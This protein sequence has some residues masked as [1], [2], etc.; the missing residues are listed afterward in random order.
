MRV[1]A[2]RHGFSRVLLSR[3]GPL[4]IHA[5]LLSLSF[6]NLSCH[7]LSVRVIGGRERRGFESELC[8]NSITHFPSQGVGKGRVLQRLWQYWDSLP[9]PHTSFTIHT[10]F[11]DKTFLKLKRYMKN[12]SLT[13]LLICLKC[14]I[15]LFYIVE[16]H[17]T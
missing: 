14:Q 10:F 1:K 13:V 15:I 4:E 12:H 3:V 17:N 6:K 7:S 5:F 11:P 16:V 2:R 8:S 9:P